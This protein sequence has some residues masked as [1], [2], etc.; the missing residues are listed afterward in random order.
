MDPDE[1]EFIEE[2]KQIDD[3]RWVVKRRRVTSGS[4]WKIERGSFRNIGC[5]TATIV[6][7]LMF[8]GLF[9]LTH[10]GPFFNCGYNSYF[11][12]SDKPNNKHN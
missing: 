10:W 3:N 12:I 1:E 8:W 4:V 5:V 7:T 2:R 9:C 11:D 6:V